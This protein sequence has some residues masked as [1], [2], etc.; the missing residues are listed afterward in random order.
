LKNVVPEANDAAERLKALCVREARGPL[1][2][3]AGPTPLMLQRGLR[4]S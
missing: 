2:R 4:F 1:V 3:N